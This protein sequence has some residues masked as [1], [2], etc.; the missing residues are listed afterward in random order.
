M[1]SKT[2]MSRRIRVSSAV[3]LRP[4]SLILPR[5]LV[6]RPPHFLLRMPTKI[7]LNASK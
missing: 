7:H 5:R 6:R 3:G 1:T 4:R 2:G